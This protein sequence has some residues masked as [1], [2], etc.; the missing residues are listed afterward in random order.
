M[1]TIINKKKFFEGYSKK[2]QAVLEKS[3][4]SVIEE[5]ASDM[6][7]CWKDGRRVFLCGNGGSAGNAIHLANDFLYGIAKQTGGGLRV[8]ALSDNPS[9]ITCLANDLSYDHI[10]S[11][12]LA[13]QAEKGDLLIALS[14][15]GNSPNILLAIEQAK[16]MQVK[17]F[18]ILGFLG[19]KCK[20]LVDVPIHFPVDD[21][22]ISE[23]LQLIV[24][25]ML[26]QWLYINRP[27]KN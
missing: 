20:E 2:L 7:K 27:Q 23:D 19:G 9:I 6:Q 3:D 12:Q 21:M 26:M 16:K 1:E 25:H 11:E 8:L 14:G 18:A 24:G 17:S 4:W 10:F 13:V 22:Q 15:S 5:L